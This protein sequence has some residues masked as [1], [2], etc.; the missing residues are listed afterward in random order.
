MLP[1][2]GLTVVPRTAAPTTLGLPAGL[3]PREGDVLRLLAAG[4]T[5]KEIA[6]VLVL[7]PGTVQSHTIHIY[8]KL[9][10]KGR[11][12]AIAFALRHG[13]LPPPTSGGS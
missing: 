4:K 2:T 6:D 5:N 9:G 3:S 10:V 13:L 12:D 11:A 7:S 8:Q 1:G